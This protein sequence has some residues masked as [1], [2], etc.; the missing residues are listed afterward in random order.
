MA[1]YY[2]S[3]KLETKKIWF[4]KNAANSEVGIVT[5]GRKRKKERNKTGFRGH[6]T[7]HRKAG[8]KKINTADRSRWVSQE[9]EKLA[10]DP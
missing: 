6:N 2:L 3:K 7:Y 4:W 9:G 1:F 5:T 10:V 8:G